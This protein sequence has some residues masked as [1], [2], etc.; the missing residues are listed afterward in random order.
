MTDGDD[1]DW[2]DDDDGDEDEAGGFD[3]DSEDKRPP[4]ESDDNG[5]YNSDDESDEQ[6]DSTPLDDVD[7]DIKRLLDGFGIGS[8]EPIES[9]SSPNEKPDKPE[10]DTDDS[11]EDTSKEPSDTG[12]SFGSGSDDNPFEKAEVQSNANPDGHDKQDKQDESTPLND[13]DAE[14]QRILDGLGSGVDDRASEDSDVQADSNPDEQPND[15]PDE[16][17]ESTPLDGTR[18]NTDDSSQDSQRD[19]T[20]TTAGFDWS[21]DDEPLEKA[22]DMQDSSNPDKTDETEETDETDDSSPSDHTDAEIQRLLDGFNAGNP[23]E[24]TPQDGSDERNSPEKSSDE[25]LDE[26]NGK[27]SS[28]SDEESDKQDISTPIDDTEQNARDQQEDTSQR[29]ADMENAFDWGSD[30]KPLEASDMQDSSNSDEE[31]EE[32]EESILLE[33]TGEDTESSETDDSQQA[34]ELDEN[35]TLID[36]ASGETSYYDE[37]DEQTGINSERATSLVSREEGFDPQVIEESRLEESYKLQGFVEVEILYYPRMSEHIYRITEPELTEFESTVRAR[38]TQDIEEMLENRP[39]EDMDTDELKETVRTVGRKQIEYQKSAVSK[40]GNDIIDILNETS[41]RLSE[42]INNKNIVE[43]LKSIELTKFEQIEESNIKRILYYIERDFVGFEKLTPLMN[44]PRIEDISCNGPG[45]PVFIYHRDYQDMVTDITYNNHELNSFVSSLAQEAG[46]HISV[47]DPDI[48]GRLPDGSRVQLTFMREISP[49]G[50]NFTV[51]KFKEEPFTPVELVDLNTFSLEQVVYLWMAIQNDK[52]LIFAGDTASGKTTSM[53]A[54][55]LFI[56]PRAK[57]VSIEDTRE[58]VL[59]HTNWVRSV[60]RESFGSNESESVDMYELLRNALR[61]RPEYLIVGEIRGNEAQTLFQAMSTG[62]TTYST[63]HAEDVPAAIHRL[64]N[65]PINLP[66]QMLESLDIMSIQVRTTVDGEIVRRCQELV[67]I[68]GVQPDT[69][70]V[71]TQTVFEHNPQTDEIVYKGE[72]K[73]LND[74]QKQLDMSDDELHAE[75]Q[76]RKLVI[77]YIRRESDEYDYEHITDILRT[78]MQEPNKVLRRIKN[79][80]L[81]TP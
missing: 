7:A 54:M 43:Y 66:R 42:K 56:P 53:N 1:F 34:S 40:Y 81:D 68:V 14:I 78:Y 58:L 28:D 51:R 30:D 20:E 49:E 31:P 2:F 76:N 64:E 65:D 36:E 61:Q 48:Q 11:N 15:E 69:H 39:V 5:S 60:T 72:S 25:S 55:S 50:S 59:R 77:D 73:V 6:D 4:E 10:E 37:D 33:D 71:K 21:P 17:D 41:D 47:A 75:I 19:D 52:S 18:E 13:T 3:W 16:K 45:V 27:E 70:R 46:K 8:D 23:S 57:V 32:Q 44:D 63:M 74:I 22:S 79:G 12:D 26:S 24:D 9:N 35:T 38:I 62:H 80:T 67:E 29:D